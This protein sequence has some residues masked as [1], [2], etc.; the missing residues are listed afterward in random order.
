MK[1][2]YDYEMAFYHEGCGFKTETDNRNGI[3]PNQNE[4]DGNPKPETETGRK[5]VGNR[6]PVT[7]RI[8]DRSDSRSVG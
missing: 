4:T 7:G 8:A 1:A 2:K 5:P 3:K 6:K